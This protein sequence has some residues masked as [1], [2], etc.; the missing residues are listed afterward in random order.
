MQLPDRRGIAG[1]LLLVAVHCGIAAQR[2]V[3]DSSRCFAGSLT[4][5]RKDDDDEDQ[6]EVTAPKLQDHCVR[7][8]EPTRASRPARSSGLPRDSPHLAARGA[9]G[10]GAFLPGSCLGRCGEAAKLQKLEGTLQSLLVDAVCGPRDGGPSQGEPRQERA[11]SS[12]AS[13]CHVPSPLHPTHNAS[14]VSWVSA[15]A[16]AA[17]PDMP[18]QDRQADHYWDVNRPWFTC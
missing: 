13:E 5:S 1:C 15:G 8:S 12:K 3:A 17:F 18:L 11:R 16:L 9:R 2:L 4:L 7:G 14:E 6:D 10:S